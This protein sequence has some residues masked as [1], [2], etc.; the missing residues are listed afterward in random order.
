MMEPFP[1]IR[2]ARSVMRPGITGLWQVRNRSNNTSVLQMI[3]DD[4]EYVRRFS[5]ALDLRILLATIPAL[6]TKAGAC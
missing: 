3:D 1:E 5:L 4:T 2:A 6:L